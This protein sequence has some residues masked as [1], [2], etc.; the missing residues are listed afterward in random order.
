MTEV[1]YRISIIIS[2]T[3]FL[4]VCQWYQEKWGRVKSKQAK[5]SGVMYFH[6]KLDPHRHKIKSMFK[7]F[8]LFT[9]IL[10]GQEERALERAM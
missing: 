5:E 6:S 1:V 4:K 10:Q 7:W 8:Y 3:V 9:V 2:V